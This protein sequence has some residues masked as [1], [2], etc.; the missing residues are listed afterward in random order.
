L[1]LCTITLYVHCDIELSSSLKGFPLRKVTI[2]SELAR[3][4]QEKYPDKSLEQIIIDTIHLHCSPSSI[5]PE[6]KTAKKQ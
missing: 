1:G 2:P 4:L 6:V 5:L 3:K